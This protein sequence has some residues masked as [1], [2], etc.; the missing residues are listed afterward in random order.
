MSTTAAYELLH[1][2]SDAALVDVVRNMSNRGDTAQIL[3]DALQHDIRVK[4]SI[5]EEARSLRCTRC[6][7]GED[8]LERR[9][10]LSQ[11]LICGACGF[12]TKLGMDFDEGR[13]RAYDDEDPDAAPHAQA[14]LSVFGEADSAA[15]V[16]G[17]RR[18]RADSVA[19]AR[20]FDRSDMVAALSGII[21][22]HARNALQPA[23]AETQSLLEL[24]FEKNARLRTR[25]F[26]E[27]RRRI[28][29]ALR[30]LRAVSAGTAPRAM[31]VPRFRSIYNSGAAFLRGAAGEWAGSR[32]ACLD[33]WRYVVCDWYRRSGIQQRN[34]HIFMLIAIVCAG[35][36]VGCAIPPERCVFEMSQC[37]GDMEHTGLSSI[38]SLDFEATVRRFYDRWGRIVTGTVAP[39][40][41]AS[42]PIEQPKTVSEL[43]AANRVPHTDPTFA[44]S[45]IVMSHISW[46]A[47][48]AVSP[49]HAHALLC[50]AERRVLVVWERRHLFN[51]TKHEAHVAFTRGHAKLHCFWRYLR[52]PERLAHFQPLHRK[53]Y[54][55]PWFTDAP[56]FRDSG[57][58][59]CAVLC[60]LPPDL[61]PPGVDICDYF[62]RRPRA[63][64]P[65]V[66]AIE[67]VDLLI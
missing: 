59:A 38:R 1:R 31:V 53:A 48:R 28:F 54:D 16:T 15:P 29:N 51:Q 64:M 24:P 19:D 14:A 40:Q 36:R 7:A 6:G 66:S 65:F 26:T 27:A 56:V 60:L 3:R 44:W 33:A 35:L 22:A 46:F 62:G 23:G 8:L 25:M 50:A 20:E 12:D 57:A 47:S 18:R 2:M 17:K 32:D 49:A 55:A 30:V 11:T 10:H 42:F 9:P 37:L 52:E 21:K 39:S 61:K 63:I 67:A 13:T 34:Y 5:E 4:E 43:L 45:H 58:W 41:S